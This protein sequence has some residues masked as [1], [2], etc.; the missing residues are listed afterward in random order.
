MC[1]VSQRYG[2]PSAPQ[3]QF[4]LPKPVIEECSLSGEDCT[5]LVRAGR[6]MTAGFQS[7]EWAMFNDSAMELNECMAF[8][9]DFRW[10]CA[11]ECVST[12]P[13]WVF[14]QIWCATSDSYNFYR[15]TIESMLLGC[16]TAWFENSSV[17]DRK[18]LQ[19]CRC[20]PVCHTDQTF[21][22]W[23]HLVLHWKGRQHNQ[24]LVPLVT[25]PSP[26]SDPAEST[27]AWKRAPPDR[28]SLL[29]LHIQASERFFHELGYC[30]C[31]LYPTE[32]TG[33]CVWIYNVPQYCKLV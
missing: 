11:V 17:E 12:R 20:S 8:V 23:L 30:P 3:T 22:H 18:E 14:Q 29:P 5:E 27:E 1:S 33:L 15:C 7:V 4:S 2:P 26:C 31:H 9:T 28:E 21:Y 6:E 10:K 19:S 13:I 25:S 32:D 24:R 16:I